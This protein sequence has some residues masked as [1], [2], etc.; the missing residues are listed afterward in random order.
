M[1]TLGVLDAIRAHPSIVKDLFVYVEKEL[2]VEDFA[3]QVQ[4]SVMGSSKYEAE[5]ATHAMWHDYIEEV[6]GNKK[7]C[8]T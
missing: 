4:Y 3:F 6:G 7:H 2:K 5:T 1:R 8:S